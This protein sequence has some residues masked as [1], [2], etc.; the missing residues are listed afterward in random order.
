VAE[1]ATVH[2]GGRFLRGG[3]APGRAR[4][5]RDGALVRI[6]RLH[7]PPNRGARPL[8]DGKGGNLAGLKAGEDAPVVVRL[9]LDQK[10]VQSIT[11]VGARR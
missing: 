11:V 9:S 7:D 1:G 10:V 4:G 8:I 3:F 6:H 2:G 5:Q